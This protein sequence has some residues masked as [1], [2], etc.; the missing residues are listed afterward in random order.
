MRIGVPTEIKRNERRV[1]LSPAGARDLVDAGHEVAVQAGAG[2]GSGFADADYERAGARIAPDAAAV[3][4]QSQLILKVKE[5]QEPEVA[6]LRPDHTLFT[7]LHLAAAP[8]LT[9]GLVASGATCIAYETIEDADG[10]LPLL[11]P[12]SEVAGKMAAQVTAFFLAR[13]EKPGGVLVGGVPGVSPASILVIGGGVAGASAAA[14]AAGLGARVTI[15]DR[16]LARLRQLDAQ[17]G[18][19]VETVFSS[20]LE[21]EQRLPSADAVIGTVLVRGARAPHVVTRADLARMRPGALL[22]DVAIDQGG[23]FETSRPTTHADP[24]YEVDGVIHYCVANIPGAVPAT[25]TRALG[26][27]TLPYALRLAEHGAQAALAA[28]P[29]FALGLNAAGGQVTYRPVAEATGL[30]FTDPRSALSA[31]AA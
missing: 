9:R 8:E 12:M 29:G 25:S 13:A 15:L 3:F 17:F 21:I 4:E 14:V 7:Y 30:E 16:D 24:V 18:G 28:D 11:A 31:I 20:R 6:L 19:A 2:T 5:P 23:C 1:A 27:A 10:R 26:N 22:V